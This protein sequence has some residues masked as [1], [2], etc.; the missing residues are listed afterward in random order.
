MSSPRRYLTRMSLFVV[1]V[2]LFGAALY[3]GLSTAFMANPLLNGV[4]FAVLVIGIVYTFRSVVA[5]RPEVEWLQS[6]QGERQGLQRPVAK[7]RLLAPMASMLG[8]RQGKAK[9]SA[10]ALRSLLDGIAAR[11]AEARELSRYLI[12]LLIFLGLLGTFWGLLDT[13]SAVGDVINDLTLESGDLALVFAD[14]QTGLEAPLSGMGT[15]FSSSLFGLSGSLVLGFLELQASQAQ[16]RFFN[17]LEDWMSGNAQ[18]STGGPALETGEGPALPTY[19]RGL[20]EQ[21]AENLDKLQRVVSVGEE[22]R[23]QTAQAITGLADRLAA[24][25]DHLRT[26]QSVMVKLASQQAEIR[27]AVGKLLEAVEGDSMGMDQSTRAHIRSIATHLAQMKEEL[28]GQR[29][30]TVEDINHEIR[31]LARTIAALAEEESGN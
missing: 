31:V 24:L 18:V 20:I 26:Q 2:T 22:Q 10:L 11:M 15:A 1:A 6:F 23:K 27:P 5:L 25:D 9:I 16:N 7:P 4:I 14:L 12:G 21:T 29:S 17:E 30:Q 19:L 8:Q 3:P 28:A 13:V